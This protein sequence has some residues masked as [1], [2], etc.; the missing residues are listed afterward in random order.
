MHVNY[1]AVRCE[2]NGYFFTVTVRYTA[3]RCGIN[4]YQF[5]GYGKNTAVSCDI[6]GNQDYGRRKLYGCQVAKLLPLDNRN[7][8]G[9]FFTV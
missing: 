2:S 6:Y 3:I 7:N 8:Y 4:G 1:T 9:D 5:H